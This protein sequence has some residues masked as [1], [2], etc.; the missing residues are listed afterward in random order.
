MTER[1]DLLDLIPL[2]R[3]LGLT[4]IQ[5]EQSEVR[6]RLAWH[7]DLGTSG[8]VLHGGAIIAT[9]DTAGA[10]RAFR[11][12]P[13]NASGTTTIESK[14]NFLRAVTSGYIVAIARPVHVGRTIVVIETDVAMIRNVSS[15]E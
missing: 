9:A 2:A 12:L 11:N 13:R 5:D 15:P 1:H 14:T 7:G 4:V 3:T 10:V 8:A 6:I